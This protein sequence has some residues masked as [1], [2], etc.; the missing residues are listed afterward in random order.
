M[1]MVIDA[2]DFSSNVGYGGGEPGDGSEP[3]AGEA[4]GDTHSCHVAPGLGGDMAESP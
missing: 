1:V 4:A 3:R 2:L